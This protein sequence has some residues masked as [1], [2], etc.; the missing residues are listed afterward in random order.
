[1]VDFF[2]NRWLLLGFEYLIIVEL[3]FILRF[4]LDGKLSKLVLALAELH[5]IGQLLDELLLLSDIFE[6]FLHYNMQNCLL[7]VKSE[8]CPLI[9]EH[10][11][12]SSKL[13]LH[14]HNQGVRLVDFNIDLL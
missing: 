12:N 7:V 8:C 13:L 10:L 9:H 1:M 6:L 3:D 11:E 14:G 2:I 5:P 4:I